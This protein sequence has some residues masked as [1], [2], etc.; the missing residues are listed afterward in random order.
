MIE[1]LRRQLDREQMGRRGHEQPVLLVAPVELTQDKFAFD[2]DSDGQNRV[3]TPFA[4]TGER[5]EL[6]GMVRESGVF[7][8]E[9]GSVGTIQQI[10]LVA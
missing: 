9:N 5:N 1:R 8:R 10:D 7:V 4:L 6:Q 3:E 2:I